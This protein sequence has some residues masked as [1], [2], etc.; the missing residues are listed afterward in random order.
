MTAAPTTQTPTFPVTGGSSPGFQEEAVRAAGRQETTGRE[1]AG[2]GDPATGD[3]PRGQRAVPSPW[4]DGQ[5]L[6]P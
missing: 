4:Q 1:E 2:R 5:Q 3:L 6:I